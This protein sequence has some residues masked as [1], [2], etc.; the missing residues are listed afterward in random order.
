MFR[1]IQ[2]GPI[3][4]PDPLKAENFLRLKGGRRGGPRDS[5]HEKDLSHVAGFDNQGATRQEMSAPLADD[6][7]ENGP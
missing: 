2:V 5:E 4:S 3:E 1:I 6:Q 7:Q